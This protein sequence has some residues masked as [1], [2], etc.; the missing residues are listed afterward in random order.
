[1]ED[2]GIETS[3]FWLSKISLKL[4][5]YIIK[6]IFLIL[7]LPTSTHFPL[8]QRGEGNI[9]SEEKVCILN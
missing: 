1:M 4:E 6:T 8:T 2:L 9:L 3:G 5:H 7:Y